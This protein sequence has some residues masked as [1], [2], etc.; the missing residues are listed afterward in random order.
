MVGST[1]TNPDQV[2][3]LNN[4]LIDFVEAQNGKTLTAFWTTIGRDFFLQWPTPESELVSNGLDPSWNGVQKTSKKK[5]KSHNME[6]TSV[7]PE[8][9]VNTDADMSKWVGLRRDVSLQLMTLNLC[10]YIHSRAL[11]IGTITTALTKE[12]DCQGTSLN[13]LYT[14]SQMSS[15]A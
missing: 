14:T 6:E 7:T 9:K 3:F 15:Q 1:W 2:V 12:S 10:A 13:C 11:K 5:K 4:R 8:A